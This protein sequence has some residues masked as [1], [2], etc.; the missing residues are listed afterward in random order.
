MTAWL[1]WKCKYHMDRRARKYS[2][3]FLIGLLSMKSEKGDH[4]KNSGEGYECF[5]TPWVPSND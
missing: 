5:D 2:K 1:F 4:I 3:F